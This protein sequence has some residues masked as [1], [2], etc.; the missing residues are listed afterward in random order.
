MM[1]KPVHGDKIPKEVIL[2]MNAGLNHALLEANDSVNGDVLHLGP[3]ILHLVD[4]V[5][6]HLGT[7]FFLSFDKQIEEPCSPAGFGAGGRRRLQRE[8]LS[9]P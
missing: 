8:R 3:L 6:G 9:V 4:E 2:E 7:E 1:H 5:A